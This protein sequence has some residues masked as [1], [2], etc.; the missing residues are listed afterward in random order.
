MTRRVKPGPSPKLLRLKVAVRELA[1]V[2]P[3]A[4]PPAASSA[5]LPH[6]PVQ[7]SAF[8][9]RAGKLTFRGR[10][11]VN[12]HILFTR[13]LLTIL[14]VVMLGGSRAHWQRAAGTEL[15]LID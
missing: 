5:P 13:M 15:A 4:P 10:R 11:A 3:E 1:I 9:L 7:L 14:A 6:A 8:P 12:T 2:V